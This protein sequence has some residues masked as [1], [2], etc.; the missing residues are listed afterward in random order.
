MKIK[1]YMILDSKG[2][3]RILTTGKSI[4]SNLKRDEI[5]IALEFNIDDSMF[6]R[7]LISAT[8]NLT[9]VKDLKLNLPVDISGVSVERIGN[10]SIIASDITIDDSLIVK[11]NEPK[12][13]II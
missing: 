13:S 1:K 6:K 7:P 11:E 10:N 8:V 9:T 2:H 5:A 3:A 4:P 12:N